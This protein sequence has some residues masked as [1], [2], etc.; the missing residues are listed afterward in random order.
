LPGARPAG[1]VTLHREWVADQLQVTGSGERLNALLVGGSEPADLAGTLAAALR[2]N[3]PAVVAAPLTNPFT[4]ALATLGFAP[5]DGDPAAVAVE[6][7]LMDGP[8]PRELV[9]GFS[10]AN[11]LRAGLSVGAGPELLVHLAAIAREAEVLGFPQIIRVLAPE[12]PEVT[13]PGCPFEGYG[14][15]GLLGYLIDTLYD[16]PTVTGRLKENLPPMPLEERVAESADTGPRLVFVRGRA[17]GVEVVCRTEGTSTEV[18]G[19]CRFYASEETAVR[20]VESGVVGEGDLIVVGGCGPRG[21]P[22]LLRLDRLAPHSATGTWA[23][24]ATPEAATGGAVWYLRD[25]DRLRLDLGE[26]LIR[27]GVG[28]DELGSREPFS[29]PV[30]TGSGY[31]ARYSRAALPALEGAGFD[32]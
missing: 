7:A 16:A 26:G 15:A 31:A 8:R 6:V 23:S 20:A 12:I 11:A 18:S 1:G 24:L 19:T 21:G 29:V 17:S 30:T 14:P 9:E 5:L 3:V 27:T 28:A 10:L 13:V 25:G 32:L 2:L 22:G 4:I